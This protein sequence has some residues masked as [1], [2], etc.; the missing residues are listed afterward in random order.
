MWLLSIRY[1]V[2]KESIERNMGKILEKQNR[3]ILNTVCTLDNNQ[4]C[5]LKKS[6]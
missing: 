2:N 6:K 3:T 1:T 4:W 5:P